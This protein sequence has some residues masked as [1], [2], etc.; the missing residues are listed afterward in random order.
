MFQAGVKLRKI[1]NSHEGKK[2]RE[3]SRKEKKGE[4]KQ[5][6]KT[7]DSLDCAAPPRDFL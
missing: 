7:T 4:R 3:N 5:S 2:S 1:K 6:G